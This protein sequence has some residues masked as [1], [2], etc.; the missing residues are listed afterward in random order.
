MQQRNVVQLFTSDLLTFHNFY[1]YFTNRDIYRM[2]LMKV[3]LHWTVDT[4][5]HVQFL[6][7]PVVHQDKDIDSDI[8]I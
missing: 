6:Q 1:Q 4:G 8:V 2:T 5:K 3:T 7:Y